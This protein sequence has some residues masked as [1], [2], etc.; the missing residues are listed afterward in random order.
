[1]TIHLTAP[2]T[3][4]LSM[5]SHMPIV[6]VQS[7]LAILECISGLCQSKHICASDRMSLLD[8]KVHLRG[9]SRQE[10]LIQPDATESKLRTLTCATHQNHG[11]THTHPNPISRE[12][13]LQIQWGATDA[14]CHI[15]G[16]S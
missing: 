15:S 10:A 12:D 4:L 9:R 13:H 11:S 1:M 3:K 16:S 5:V 6:T 14:T 7:Y 2:S 8:E